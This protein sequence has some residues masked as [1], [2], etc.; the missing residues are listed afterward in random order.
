MLQLRVPLRSCCLRAPELTDAC[1]LAQRYT[2][3]YPN[4]LLEMPKIIEQFRVLIYSGDFDAQIP[5]TGTEEWTRGLGYNESAP[6][7]PWYVGAE[8]AS[9][10]AGYAVEYDVPTEFTF[11]TVKA[12][13]HMVPTFKP[14]EA[15]AMVTRFVRGEPY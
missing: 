3:T 4:L 13:G 9:S 14:A 2:R 6:W 11:L 7:H 8:G 1:G 12:A 5:H 10:V 15:L